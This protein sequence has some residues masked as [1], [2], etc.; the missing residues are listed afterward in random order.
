MKDT[1]DAPNLGQRM[2]FD[3]DTGDDLRASCVLR[4][5]AS[6]PTHLHLRQHERFEIGSGE[7]DV[8]VDGRRRRF[9]PGS[10]L[11]IA[12]GVHHRFRNCSAEAV[13]VDIT[14]WPAL[15]TRR[16]FETL[17]ALDADG[18]LNRMGAPGPLRLGLLTREFGD[19]LFLLGRVP[20]RMQLLVGR[21]LG[22]LAVRL[23]RPA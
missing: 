10:G 7:L 3:R 9:G 4:A 13:Q 20:P 22:A 5:G 1:I 23:G 14:I 16:L 11:T 12:P 18:A 6:T 17:F 21:L 8:W 2:T 19:E 15:R